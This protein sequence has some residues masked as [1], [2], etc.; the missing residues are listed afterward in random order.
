MEAARGIAEIVDETMASAA[1]VHAVEN[2]KDTSGRT[3][4]AF[5]G[6]APLHAARLA[7]KLGIGRVVVPADAGVG[8]AVGFL[9]AP[10]AY[11]V[12]RTLL[13]RLDQ[14]DPGAIEAMFDAMRIEAE[15]VV[16]LGAPMAKLVETRTG[17]MRYRGQ[18]H[19]IAVAIQPGP[20]DAAVLRALFDAAYDRLYGR[21]IP[22]LEVE[23]VTWVLSLAEQD[24]LPGVAS[25][26]ARMDPGAPLGTRRVV[27]PATGRAAEATLWDRAAL[28]PG[29]ML[30][31]PAVILESGTSTIVPPGFTAR[32][33]AG[34]ELVLEVGP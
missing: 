30:P 9:K 21:L 34:G 26:P 31:G 19:E 13:A 25:T 22:G 33:A 12:A 18:G 10:I 7:Q 14:L 28:P 32:I 8:S 3:L 17:F 11:E 27:D 4:I 16:R 15:A 6:A 24:P 1:R 23:A 2:G 5:G 20:A 29:A